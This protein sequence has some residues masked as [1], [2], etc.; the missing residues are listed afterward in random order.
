MSIAAPAGLMT[1]SSALAQNL[2]PV[3]I[4]LPWIA[5]GSNYW[6]IIGKKL[7]FFS[8]RGIDANIARGFGSVAAAQAVAN[9]QFDFG[10][11]F[12]GGTILAAARGLPL[13]MLATVYYDATMGTALRQD[14]P[15]KSPKD[16]EGKKIGIVPTSAEA[17]FWP[18]FA[19]AAG[20]DASKVSIVQLDAKVVERTLID[21][22]VDA[23]TA[24][25]TS[26]IPVMVS[27]GQPPR[28]M[29]W[30]KFGI[31]LYAAQVVTRQ[32]IVDQDPQLC[33]AV[34]DAVL[35]SYAY[36]L[37]EPKKSIDLFIQEL[38]EVGLIKGGRENAEL[39]Q[40]LAQLM[41][42][43]PEAMNNSL[44]WTD[45]SKLPAMIDLVMKYAA[46]KDAKAPGPEKLATNKFAGKFKLTSSE[47]D[48]IKKST[49][50]YA[51]Y[52]G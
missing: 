49:A 45:M 3:K 1:N 7:G 2:K 18:A 40:G 22:Q 16:L 41:T 13:V 24:I 43:R 9:K 29:L 23:I 39:S 32:E 21:K 20:F 30:S 27:V 35:E 34:V 5:N 46:P 8:K 38:P 12:A 51:A 4:T 31:E 15:I 10:V 47:W 52:L 25:G 17:P 11:V 33:Q 6:P 48:N 37:R 28:F 19:A 50:S 36:T 42:I 44:G 26:S 14:S